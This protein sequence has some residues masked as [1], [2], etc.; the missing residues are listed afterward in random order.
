MAIQSTAYATPV[1]VN[2]YAC[3]D[4]TDV[5]LAKKNI[6]PQHPKSG[7]GNADAVS[8]PSRSTADPVK[9][10]AVK[11]AAEETAQVTVGYSPGGPVNAV[12]EPG[13]LVSLIF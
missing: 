5:G 7:P 2:G 12:A 10:A 4:C 8:D 11:R 6:D 13:Q 3:R 1:Q 9:I